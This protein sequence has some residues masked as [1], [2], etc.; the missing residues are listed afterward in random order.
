MRRPYA[1]LFLLS[2]DTPRRHAEHQRP[3]DQQHDQNLPTCVQLSSRGQQRR[4]TLWRQ[5][6]SSSSYVLP[7][8]LGVS[9]SRHETTL[10]ERSPVTSVSVALKAASSVHRRHCDLSHA[11]SCSWRHRT[12]DGHHCA[13]VFTQAIF[14]WETFRPSVILVL[15]ALHILYFN[16]TKT[17]PAVSRRVYA[18]R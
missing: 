5:R 13:R 9:G 2:S 14:R 17:D 15:L 1:H 18:P 6:W 10:A 8:Q 4:S 3:R 12:D 16:K 11:G 7:A